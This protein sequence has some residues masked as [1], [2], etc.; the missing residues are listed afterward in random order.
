MGPDEMLTVK[1]LAI[2]FN[3]SVNYGISVKFPTPSCGQ[4]SCMIFPRITYFLSVRTIIDMFICGRFLHVHVVSRARNDAYGMARWM[5]G[6]V[7]L[8]TS[9]VW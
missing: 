2:F 8:V 5:S 3:G 6:D 7:S 9:F 4:L 1:L